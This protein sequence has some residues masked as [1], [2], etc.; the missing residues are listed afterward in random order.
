[1]N[2]TTISK[3]YSIEEASSILSVKPSWLRSQLF[4]GKIKHVKLNRLVRISE[5]Y[6]LELLEKNTK[7]GGGK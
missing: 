6:L 2:N 1:M 4:Q 7:G 5:D 3:L